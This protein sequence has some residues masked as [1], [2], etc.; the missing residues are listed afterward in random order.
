MDRERKGEPK[1]KLLLDLAFFNKVSH[2]L[3]YEVE[4]LLLGGLLCGVVNRHLLVDLD[5][6]F[7]GVESDFQDTKVTSSCFGQLQ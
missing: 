5:Y 3:A 7:A 4:Q 6:V 2:G 1:R